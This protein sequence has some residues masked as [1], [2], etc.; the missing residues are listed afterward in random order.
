MSMKYLGAYLLS[1]IAGEK[2]SAEKMK[3]IMDAAGMEVDAAMVKLVLSKMEG[4]SVSEVL[5]SGLS[6]LEATGGGGELTY[7]VFVF[8]L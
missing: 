7:F 3:E 8:V 2:P 6:N 4:K 1:A 5:A